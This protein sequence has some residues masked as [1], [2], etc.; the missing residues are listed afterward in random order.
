MNGSDSIILFSI[1]L[2]LIY[3]TDMDFLKVN[4]ISCHFVE[5]ANYFNKFFETFE[6]SHV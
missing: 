2:S 3:R 1:Y 4:F 6:F 5:I